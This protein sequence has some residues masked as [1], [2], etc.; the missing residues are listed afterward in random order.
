[1]PVNMN[2]MMRAKRRD[3]ESYM[4]QPP[5]AA[6]DTSVVS[7]SD[8]DQPTDAAPADVAAALP[9]SVGAITVLAPGDEASPDMY[10]Y[11]KMDTGAWMV[12][13]PGVPCETGKSRVQLDHAATEAE[14]ADME[15]ALEASDQTK[16]EAPDTAEGPAEGGAY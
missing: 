8:S 13:P 10:T 14:Y 5:K 1:M 12:Y 3:M 7:E 15:A 16:S 2:D 4:Y 11:E 6:D 9:D